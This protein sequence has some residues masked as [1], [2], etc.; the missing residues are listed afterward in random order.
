M[1][2]WAPAP[3][4]ANA[5]ST[6]VG[7][8]ASPSGP[9]VVERAK[10]PSIKLLGVTLRVDLL[11]ASLLLTSLLMA[12]SVFMER[13]VHSHL[14]PLPSY[15]LLSA[16]D[17]HRTPHTFLSP[18]TR[19]RAQRALEA[20]RWLEAFTLVCAV[21]QVVNIAKREGVWSRPGPAAWASAHGEPQGEPWGEG[22]LSANQV[23]DRYTVPLLAML[24]EVMLYSRFALNHPLA[25]GRFDGS[26]LLT[27]GQL[28]RGLNL[29]PMLSGFV[30]VGLGLLLL[31]LLKHMVSSI[32]ASDA[33]NANTNGGV[34]AMHAVVRTVVGGGG[35]GGGAQKRARF[36]AVGTWASGI[37]LVLMLAVLATQ[38]LL[39]L[40]PMQL[41][42]AG[43]QE[44]WQLHGQLAPPLTALLN[45][46]V[47]AHTQAASDDAELKTL[48]AMPCSYQSQ[49]M[50]DAIGFRRAL[51]PPGGAR[52]SREVTAS[53][54]PPGWTELFGPYFRFGGEAACPDYRER[55]TVCDRLCERR[56]GEL[57]KPLCSRDRCDNPHADPFGAR[58]VTFD[59]QTSLCGAT[60]YK[61]VGKEMVPKD[62]CGAVEC[63]AL[64]TWKLLAVYRND[65]RGGGGGGGPSG[66][67][68][69]LE[70]LRK[71]RA[72]LL[73]VPFDQLWATIKRGGEVALPRAG[74]EVEVPVADIKR[75]LD[76]LAAWH[77]RRLLPAVRLAIVRGSNGGSP[78]PAA[79]PTAA[80]PLDSPIKCAA[81]QFEWRPSL[82][83]RGPDHDPNPCLDEA[84][85]AIVRSS[86]NSALGPTPSWQA[87]RVGQ[88][89][90]LAMAWGGWRAPKGPLSLDPPRDECEFVK[91]MWAVASK[92]QHSPIPNRCGVLASP[93]WERRA[94]D[95]VDE[96]ADG[97][98]EY[99]GEEDFRAF[100][101]SDD[102]DDVDDERRSLR[103]GEPNAT[104]TSAN[105]E[106]SDRAPQRRAHISGGGGGRARTAA[107][108]RKAKELEEQQSG[109]TMATGCGDVKSVGK[110]PFAIAS[111]A[112]VAVDVLLLLDVSRVPLIVGYAVATALV[113][114]S[115][116]SIYF[117]ITASILERRI[118]A[119]AHG[120]GGANGD[121][122]GGGGSV[123]PSKLWLAAGAALKAVESSPL[124]GM[125]GAQVAHEVMR[126][127]MR[128][129]AD[130]RQ[131]S[132]STE[133]PRTQ[134]R[135]KEAVSGFSWTTG[136][137]LA[138]AE[139]PCHP[140]FA[141]DRSVPEG[142]PSARAYDAMCLSPQMAEMRASYSAMY[143]PGFDYRRDVL[144]NGPA[145]P[146][147]KRGAVKDPIP[148]S[149]GRG[150]TGGVSPS[151]TIG[152][153]AAGAGG[154][155]T[156]SSL[157]W[158]PFGK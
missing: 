88:G 119:A 133:D 86:R 130:A 106:R 61:A 6:L 1:L 142:Y 100:G 58:P 16:A 131:P 75:S 117:C 80:D 114:V 139:R 120:P 20:A 15:K 70:M 116:L 105:D 103:V 153:K 25:S 104:P 26:A 110:L 108:E 146:P 87:W 129:A 37:S 35:E 38:P 125:D 51:E 145:P 151:R 23:F 2:S 115:V 12:H 112:L 60:L 19:R 89:V 31:L 27:G 81:K 141:G 5:T 54:L 79:S 109:V 71:H 148:A 98:L 124:L 56:L 95:P 46:G 34:G 69:A 14:D 113:L 49:L 136:A 42:P 135:L 10:W 67:E 65:D 99:V 63:A 50:R 44:P 122:G 102:V 154:S 147:R 41:K 123:T 78:F 150:A 137:L 4:P 59:P 74:E 33:T 121:G 55:C 30:A 126:R 155:S 52:C 22:A 143:G 111:A 9:H 39:L 40:A 72:P 24:G 149:G 94:Y 144:Q 13:D 107:A 127:V 18:E 134:V 17:P 96:V 66:F 128:E 77:R 11:D 53:V 97:E 101:W 76:L 85:S 3:T 140:M 7:T 158:D 45:Q 83:D 47:A 132:G 32:S 118:E 57:L 156:S 64:V 68:R 93:P 152:P 36:E 157:R 21:W 91:C 28:M 29:N 92:P 138:P 73:F 84:L 8:G 82:V 62:S 90:D 43:S 48:S